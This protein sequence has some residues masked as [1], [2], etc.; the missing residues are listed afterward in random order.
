MRKSA[1][2]V[3]S[4]ALAVGVGACGSGDADPRYGA[5]PEPVASQ[6]EGFYITQDRLDGGAPSADP[7]Q[8][9]PASS[10]A[11]SSDA[12]AAGD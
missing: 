3:V 8:S 6:G 10:S 12:S 7:T 2:V 1:W 11:S 4:M 5:Q 9:Q